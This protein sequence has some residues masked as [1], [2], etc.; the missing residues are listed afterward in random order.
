M[1]FAPH[2]GTLAGLPVSNLFTMTCVK[3][4][5]LLPL[6]HAVVDCTLLVALIAWPDRPFWREN[7]ALH[8]PA[9][10]Q[11]ALFLQEGGSVEWDLTT[12]PPPGPFILIMSGNPPAGLA[13]SIL[14][15][16]AGVV[17]RGHRWDPIWFL[18][19]EAVAFPC[20]YLLGVW[21]D[22]GR[23]RLG[24]VMTAFLAWRVLIVF[25]GAYEVGWRVQVMFWW[26]FTLWLAWLGL[27]HLVRVGLRIAKR[28]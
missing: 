25:I 10:I 4:R 26:G 5:W 21:V 23:F 14:R 11:A 20:W 16:Q 7:G 3:W 6:G 8:P 27:S 12:L 18:V 22:A 13:S 17:R 1:P 2:Q 9:A 19:H 24:K 28:S 15:P